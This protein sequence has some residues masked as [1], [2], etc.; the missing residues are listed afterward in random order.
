MAD[1]RLGIPP[2]NH[3]LTIKMKHGYPSPMNEANTDVIQGT[4]DMLLLPTSY[5]RQGR[6][7]FAELAP[8]PQINS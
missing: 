7:V 8:P 6:L 2:D 5:V 1:L 4:L 3:I